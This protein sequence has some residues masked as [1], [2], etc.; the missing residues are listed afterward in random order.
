MIRRPPRSTLFPYTTLFRSTGDQ[1]G[2]HEG[3]HR[4]APV[5][6]SIEADAHQALVVRTWPEL[7]GGLDDDR[8]RAVR[9]D[10]ELRQVVARDV[11]HHLAAALHDRPFGGH[12]RDT[13]EQIARRPVEGP[14]RP[15]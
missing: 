5:F 8:E 2:R 15:P 4:C 11:L 10:E 9:A 6:Q 12:D 3:A 13:D 7:E 1:I 14:P